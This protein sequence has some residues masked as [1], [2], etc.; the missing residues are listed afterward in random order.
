MG[1]DELYAQHPSARGYLRDRDGYRLMDRRAE[2]CD[3]LLEEVRGREAGLRSGLNYPLAP[4][5]AAPE[6]EPSQGR[7][8]S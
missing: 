1:L 2:L 3:Q 7:P 8:K 6:H 4:M 5:E